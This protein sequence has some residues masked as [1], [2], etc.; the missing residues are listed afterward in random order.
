[1]TRPSW[2]LQ[3]WPEPPHVALVWT[4][5]QRTYDRVGADPHVGKRLVQLLAE[6]GLRPVRISQLPFGACAGQPE[7]APLLRNLADIFRGARDAIL[8][9]GGVREEELTAALESLKAFESRRDGAFW[10]TTRWAE[11]RRE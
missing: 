9:T 10:Y 7:F 8:A 5:Y 2:S 1:M 11:G 4:A 6:A 3:I